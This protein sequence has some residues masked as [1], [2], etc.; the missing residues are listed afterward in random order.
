M[1][2]CEA[3]SVAELGLEVLEMDGIEDWSVSETLFLRRVGPAGTRIGTVMV[4]LP[5]PFLST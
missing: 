1:S 2:E 5:S 3:C 4:T